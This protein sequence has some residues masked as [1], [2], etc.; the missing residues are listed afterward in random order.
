MVVKIEDEMVMEDTVS[1]NSFKEYNNEMMLQKKA[2]IEFIQKTLPQP[3]VDQPN[4]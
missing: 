2:E 1:D 4:K 3:V